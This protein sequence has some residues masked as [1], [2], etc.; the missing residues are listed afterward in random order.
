MADI[1]IDEARTQLHKLR[2][3][4]PGWGY[5]RQGHIFVE[6]TVIASLAL[7]AQASATVDDWEAAK[8]AAAWLAEIQQPSGAVGISADQSSPPWPTSYA[9]LLWAA[10]NGFSDEREAGSRFLLGVR[11]KSYPAEDDSIIGHD[12]SLVGWPWVA[13]THSWVEPTALAI[14]A[15]SPHGYERHPR[16]LEGIRLLRDRALPSGGW[17]LGGTFVFGTELRP[18]PGTTGLALLALAGTRRHDRIVTAACEYLEAALKSIRAPQSLCWGTLGLRAWGRS[19][20]VHRAWLEESFERLENNGSPIQIAYL[21]LAS[22]QN[23]LTLL[24]SG[25]VE[26]NA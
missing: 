6:P 24:E 18:R 20:D 1:W 16:T 5:K 13:D 3:N 10:V 8:S 14:L 26:K 19:E 23:A 2:D 12:T 9:V 15:L 7:L 25:T 11:G 21:L 4:R 22:G 17:N